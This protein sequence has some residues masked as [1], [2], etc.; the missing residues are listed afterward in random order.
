MSSRDDLAI[1]ATVPS[2]DTSPR[3]S[4]P[5]M[6]CGNSLGWTMRPFLVGF[7]SRLSPSR[8][9]SRTSTYWLPSY[10]RKDTHISEVECFLILAIVASIGVSPRCP[11]SIIARQPSAELHLRKR[12]HLP[13]CPGESLELFQPRLIPF[14]E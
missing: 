12:L 10:S 7:H 13:D 9:C 1:V 5:L 14:L 4:S 6:T 11:S 8:K 2:S 3:A